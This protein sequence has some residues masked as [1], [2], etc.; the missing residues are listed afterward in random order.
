MC[1][2]T[3]APDRNP[4]APRPRCWAIFPDH[5][6]GTARATVRSAERI[7]NDKRESAA[8]PQL[9]I[10]LMVLTGGKD[11]RR[12]TCS[13]PQAPLLRRDQMQDYSGYGQPTMPMPPM[14]PPPR[15]RRPAALS[16]LL[17]ALA[18]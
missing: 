7:T 10:S 18:A 3:T 5:V 9:I 12:P 8:P 1:R 13:S 11:F 16:Y 4:R 15:R 6:R 17:V 14:P 2:W